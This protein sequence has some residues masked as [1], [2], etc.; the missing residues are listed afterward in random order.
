MTSSLDPITL[1]VLSLDF[2]AGTLNATKRVLDVVSVFPSSVTFPPAL[3]LAMLPALSPTV[4]V[5]CESEE[6]VVK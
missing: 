2:A 1:I 3:P 5:C 6:I 4:T